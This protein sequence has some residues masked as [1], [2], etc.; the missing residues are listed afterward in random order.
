[1]PLFGPARVE[2]GT[3]CT[4]CRRGTYTKVKEHYQRDGLGKAMFKGF[5]TGATGKSAS[6]IGLGKATYRCSA[7]GHEVTN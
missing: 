4:K 1:M 2:E 7:C 5:M 3:K 6:E